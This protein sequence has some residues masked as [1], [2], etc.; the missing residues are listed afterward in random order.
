MLG[1]V[2]ISHDISSYS[3]VFLWSLAFRFHR[4]GL[5]KGAS[6]VLANLLQFCNCTVYEV[7][8]AYCCVLYWG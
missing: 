5:H 1:V 6:Q 8:F 4:V 2:S 3:A 7:V